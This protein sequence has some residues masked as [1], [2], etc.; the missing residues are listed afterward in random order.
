MP[1][2]SLM[3]EREQHTR[4]THA[5][6]ERGSGPCALHERKEGL[7]PNGLSSLNPTRLGPFGL[8]GLW[9]GP[10]LPEFDSPKNHCPLHSPF[11]SETSPRT[12][13]VE[14]Y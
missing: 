8:L 1:A 13:R 9:K 10:M 3:N 4:T 7:T 11:R 12:Q 6:Y 14:F 2:T 5:R